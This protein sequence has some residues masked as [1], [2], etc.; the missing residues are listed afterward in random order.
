LRGGYGVDQL[1]F[2]FRCF[3]RHGTLHYFCDESSLEL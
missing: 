3:P 2:G 1:S